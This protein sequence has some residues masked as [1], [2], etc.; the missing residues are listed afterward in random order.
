MKLHGVE[1]QSFHPQVINFQGKWLLKLNLGQTQI[2][3]KCKSI[4]Q[5]QSKKKRKIDYIILY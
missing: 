5:F 1:T 2:I 3:I 4:K